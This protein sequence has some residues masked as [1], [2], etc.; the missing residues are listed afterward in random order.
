M[1]A[2]TDRP[3]APP[4]F[5]LEVYA[6]ESDQRIAV[7]KPV[8]PDDLDELLDPSSEVR[9]AARPPIGDFL[10]L[11]AWAAQVSGPMALVGSMT[12]IKQLPLDHRAGFLMSL[13]DD[14][15]M[16]LETLI[17]VSGMPRADALTIV[18]ELHDAGVIEFR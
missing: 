2:P 16:D 13:M 8:R 18:R 17:E 4:E 14:G 5:D 10:S 1:P 7:A 15:T 9:L 12:V 6:R 11:E 3:T